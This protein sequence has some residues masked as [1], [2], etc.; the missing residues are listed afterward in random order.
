MI[1]QFFGEHTANRR[2][3]WRKI[4]KDNR[5]QESVS[6]QTDIEHELVEEMGF[7]KRLAE[8]EDRMSRT[9]DLSLSFAG[10]VT[11]WLVGA[12]AYHA[13]EGWTFGDS[14]YFCYVTFFTIGF[15]SVQPSSFRLSTYDNG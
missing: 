11:F 5:R 10:F 12:A 1:I 15:V 4:Y 6:S 2:R 8:Q 9:S 7:L 13:I 3:R 14:V